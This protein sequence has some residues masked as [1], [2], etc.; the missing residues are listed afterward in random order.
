MKGNQTFQKVK[1]TLRYWNKYNIYLADIC[2]NTVYCPVFC[3]KYSM[4]RMCRLIWIYTSRTP[5][6]MRIYQGLKKELQF[7]HTASNKKL[8]TLYEKIPL[9]LWNFF[10]QRTTRIPWLL[11]CKYSLK[12]TKL[13][14]Y[15][16]QHNF[17][18]TR[19][20]QVL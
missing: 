4:C 6:K 9:C 14:T 1:T 13:S 3:Q 19:T 17:G 16:L 20:K 5:I 12:V 18:E 2:N 10:F 7:S 8:Q 15:N 11:F